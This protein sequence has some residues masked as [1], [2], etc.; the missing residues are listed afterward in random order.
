M[1]VAE[2]LEKVK[3]KF[4]DIFKKEE[5]QLN[6]DYWIYASIKGFYKHIEE[7]E[8]IDENI[9]LPLLLCELI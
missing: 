2:T 1:T 6:K 3:K 5:F 9:F 7:I 4:T 8:F